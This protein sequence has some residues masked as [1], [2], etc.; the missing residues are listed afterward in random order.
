MP[1]PRAAARG[2][3]S[4]ES[5]A[6]A[7]S[8]RGSGAY[9]PS[10][11]NRWVLKNLAMPSMTLGLR[12][13]I[14]PEP[15]TLVPTYR[16]GLKLMEVFSFCYF[17]PI[18]KRE[19][20]PCH[21]HLPGCLRVAWQPA[22]PVVLRVVQDHPG[23]LLSLFPPCQ[24]RHCPG[25]STGGDRGIEMPPAPPVL[26]RLVSVALRPAYRQAPSWPW[27]VPLCNP[28]TTPVMRPTA[29]DGVASRYQRSSEAG[30]PIPA[31][32]MP[33]EGGRRPPAGRP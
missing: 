23:P 19:P 20:I 2:T 25:G 12:L 1:R 33:A 16:A 5:L 31:V 10:Q 27:Q 24:E 15:R 22:S 21:L 3:R 9:H 17:R 26:L 28:W 30:S 7:S 6:D 8:A 4:T 32:A 11:S 18:R 13:P 29:P 14:G